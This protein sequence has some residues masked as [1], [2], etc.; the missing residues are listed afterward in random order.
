MQHENNKYNLWFGSLDFLTMKRMT[1]LRQGFYSPEDSYQSFV[2]ACE[3]W[4]QETPQIEKE[5]IY[6]TYNY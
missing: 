1:R 4:W 6:Q 5:Y 2:N 3:Q